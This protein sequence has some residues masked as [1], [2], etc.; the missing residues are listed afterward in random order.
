MEG[1]GGMCE[2]CKLFT[3]LYNKFQEKDIDL[4]ITPFTKN[5]IPIAVGSWLKPLVIH[6]GFLVKNDATEK[7]AGIKTVTWLQ[8]Q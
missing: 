7:Y 5:L 3:Q 6:R 8:R 1:P 2:L 4:H